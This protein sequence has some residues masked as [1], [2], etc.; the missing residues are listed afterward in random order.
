MRQIVP[1]RLD[2]AAS[3]ALTP[4]VLLNEQ[5][6]GCTPSAIYI[7]LMHKKFGLLHK[8]EYAGIISKMK[9]GISAGYHLW[10]AYG[11]G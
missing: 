11:Q 2:T 4:P 7:S 9:L 6:S 8:S 1:S 3:T 5:L 10:S